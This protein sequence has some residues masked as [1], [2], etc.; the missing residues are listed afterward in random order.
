E[1][2]GEFGLLESARRTA[3]VRAA[4][5]SELYELDKGSFERLL[6]DRAEIAGFAPT[7]HQTAELAA[8]PPF[9]HLADGDLRLLAAQGTWVNASPGEVLM[10]QG[11]VGDAFYVIAS[12][13]LDIV[14]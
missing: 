8:L 14:V 7:L 10:P 2:F 12:G 3:T 1:G 6:A 13:Q 11:E 4:E 5:R 9:G